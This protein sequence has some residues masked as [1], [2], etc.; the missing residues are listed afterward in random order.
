MALSDLFTRRRK[1]DADSA[2]GASDTPVHATKALPR[3]IACVSTRAHPVVLDLGPVVGGNIGFFGQQL[4][5]KVIVQ[6]VS[7]DIDRHA[8]EGKLEA[9]PAFLAQR[10][11]HESGSIDGVLCWDVFD[12][13]DTAAAKSLASQLARLLR[14]DGVLMALFATAEPQVGSRPTYT[15]HIVVDQTTLE[16]RPYAAVRPRQRP[17]PNRDIQRLFEPLR[18]VEQFLLKTNLREVL[19]RKPADPSGAAGAPPHA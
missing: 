3:F 9:L 11:P 19:L 12:H 6:D 15:K 5:C 10:F 8:R 17:L 13:M 16:Y 14:T 18:V 4:G 1:G 2:T 7:I